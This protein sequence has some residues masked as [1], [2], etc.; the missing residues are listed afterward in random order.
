MNMMCLVFAFEAKHLEKQMHL[1]YQEEYWHL[2]L[3]LFAVLL[4]HSL[5]RVLSR[6]E[7]RAF[8]I[9][10]NHSALQHWIVS[11]IAMNTMAIVPR[12]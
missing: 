2:H 8:S 6:V 7:R 12:W 10:T 9:M 5:L 11:V 4:V 3:Q 1:R